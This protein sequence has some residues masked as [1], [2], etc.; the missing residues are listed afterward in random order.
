LKDKKSMADV[1]ALLLAV[2]EPE[3][4][5]GEEYSEDDASPM[6]LASEAMETFLDAVKTGNTEEALTSFK[7]LLRVCPMMDEDEARE[8]DTTP[9]EE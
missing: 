4:K 8:D 9:S 5:G 2:D 1:G 3:E 6:A 7:S